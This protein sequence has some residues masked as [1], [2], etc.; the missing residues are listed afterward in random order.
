MGYNDIYIN[1]IYLSGSLGKKI[2]DN[3]KGKLEYVNNKTIHD[4]IL[5]D[6]EMLIYEDN[7]VEFIGDNKLI[8]QQDLISKIN[9][10]LI[11]LIYNVKDKPLYKEIIKVTNNEDSRC[12]KYYI[13]NIELLVSTALHKKEY[14]NLIKNIVTNHYVLENAINYEYLLFSIYDAP[15]Y[16]EALEAYNCIIDNIKEDTINSNE[17][18]DHLELINSKEMKQTINHNLEKIYINK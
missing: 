2:I 3:Y 15:T 16:D 14:F 11:N 17:V 10:Y 6:A 8:Y 1:D 7:K 13:F 5:D 12:S 4:Y 18:Y 9:I